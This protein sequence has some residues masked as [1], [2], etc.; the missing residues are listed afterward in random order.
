MCFRKH[1]SQRIRWTLHLQVN[2]AAACEGV[3][4]KGFAGFGC[5]GTLFGLALNGNQKD[6]HNLSGF[7]YFDAYPYVRVI[8]P[9]GRGDGPGGKGRASSDLLE[10]SDL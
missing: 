1:I 3:R 6:N 5:V 9:A 8:G 10:G 4:E 2:L 7:S